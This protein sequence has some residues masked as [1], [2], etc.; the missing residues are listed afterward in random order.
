MKALQEMIT[1][2]VQICFLYIYINKWDN[3]VNLM[4]FD[5]KIQK[6]DANAHNATPPQPKS[7]LHDVLKILA[8]SKF[9]AIR[10]DPLAATSPSTVPS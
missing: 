3:G 2:S 9:C 7:K 6:K 10:A 1:K 8:P 4:S 5:K